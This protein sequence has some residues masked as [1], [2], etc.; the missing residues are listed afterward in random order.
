LRPF[1]PSAPRQIQR[2]RNRYKATLKNVIM[3]VDGK[4]YMFGKMVGEYTW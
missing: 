2:T 3:Q 1:A 4:D